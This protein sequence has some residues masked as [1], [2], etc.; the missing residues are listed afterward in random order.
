MFSKSILGLIWSI[1]LSVQCLMDL[2][3]IELRQLGP[4]PIV[5]ASDD[6][7]CTDEDHGHQHGEYEVE[8]Y[9]ETLKV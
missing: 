8:G 3:M 1:L 7:S 6:F 5:V 2:I 9:L 4:G